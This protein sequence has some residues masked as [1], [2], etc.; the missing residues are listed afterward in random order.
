MNIEDFR[1]VEKGSYLKYNSYI[2]LVDK[3]EINGEDYI[4][5]FDYK[6][7]N[8]KEGKSKRKLY[9]NDYQTFSSW[10]K[11]QLRY[12]N[13]EEKLFLTAAIKNDGI[14]ASERIETYVEKQKLMQL[15]IDN[16]QSDVKNILKILQKNH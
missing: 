1:K 15:S 12:A 11:C 3:T 16:I 13:R 2:F 14:P 4:I 9:S 8:R 10:E 7:K 6:I 5:H